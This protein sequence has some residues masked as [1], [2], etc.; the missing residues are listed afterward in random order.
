MASGS[1]KPILTGPTQQDPTDDEIDHGFRKPCTCDNALSPH[2]SIQIL[3]QG[4][5]YSGIIGWRCIHIPLL[6]PQCNIFQQ[7]NLCDCSRSFANPSTKLWHG[8]CVS[9]Q[10]CN[11]SLAQPSDSHRV[12]GNC[13]EILR[14]FHLHASLCRG[15][16]RIPSTRDKSGELYT[17]EL[18]NRI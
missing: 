1:G 6:R 12:C 17:R 15:I 18:E 11:E 5:G 3:R 9:L 16:L 14:C 2:G 7:Y 13:M 4:P 10:R 8:I